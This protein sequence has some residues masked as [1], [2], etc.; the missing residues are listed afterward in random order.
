[1]ER[2]TDGAEK[3]LIGRNRNSSCDGGEVKGRAG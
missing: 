3:D 1:M 2:L